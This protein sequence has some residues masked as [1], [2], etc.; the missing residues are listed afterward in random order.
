MGRKPVAWF[1]GSVAAIILGF[2]LTSAAPSVGTVVVVAGIL[3]L[4]GFLLYVFRVATTQDDQ[5]VWQTPG[6]PRREHRAEEVA[7]RESEPA[8]TT[9]DAPV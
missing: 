7:K 2:V 1:V 3:G 6:K 4:A 9:P 5:W 8:P